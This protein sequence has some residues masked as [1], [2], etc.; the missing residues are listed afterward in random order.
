MEAPNDASK[1][2]EPEEESLRVTARSFWDAVL[3]YCSTSSPSNEKSREITGKETSQK[4]IK[5]TNVNFI[6][7]IIILVLSVLVGFIFVRKS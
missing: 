6:A 2:L 4:T 1:I 7:A 3:P 5:P